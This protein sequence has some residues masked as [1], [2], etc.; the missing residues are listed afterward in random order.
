MVFYLCN[1][2]SA[3]CNFFSK[4]VLIATY[5]ISTLSLNIY[6][7]ILILKNIRANSKMAICGQLMRNLG[8]YNSFV[9]KLEK[10]YLVFYKYHFQYVQSERKTCMIWLIWFH[11]LLIFLLAAHKKVCWICIIYSNFFTFIHR[12]LLLLR[13]L[14]DSQLYQLSQLCLF[15]K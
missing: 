6:I 5:H 14:K 7:Y 9:F 10:T 15:R 11:N 12:I 8:K 3:L 13:K 4:T 2:F 1:F